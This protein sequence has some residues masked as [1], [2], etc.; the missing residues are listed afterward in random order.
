MHVPIC[1]LCR[2]PNNNNPEREEAHDGYKTALV[3]QFNSLYGTEV[4]DIESWRG[5]S[6]AL[7]IFPL[8]NDLN[9]AK[10]NEVNLETAWEQ[11]FKGKFINLVDLVDTENTG[12]C[13][14]QF[15]TLEELKER[16]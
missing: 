11:M 6:R 8:P 9:K 15:N 16:S 14:T 10:K 13:A 1:I 12:Q 4:D 5:L 7:D 3:Q 2:S